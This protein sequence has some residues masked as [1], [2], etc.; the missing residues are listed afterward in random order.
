MFVNLQLNT[1]IIA[2]SL[3]GYTWGSFHLASNNMA[4]LHLIGYISINKCI[5]F[6]GCDVVQSDKYLPSASYYIVKV[7]GTRHRGLYSQI[8]NAAG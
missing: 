6:K 4:L 2:L 3:I 5:F 1:C 8:D 7:L